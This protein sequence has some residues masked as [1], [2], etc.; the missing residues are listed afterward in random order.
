MI[1]KVC[2]RQQRGK[3]FICRTNFMTRELFAG[4]MGR[5][6]TP[7]NRNPDK[8]ELRFRMLAGIKK[9]R[10]TGPFKAYKLV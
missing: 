7:K 5:N 3:T 2:R 10:Y 4:G 6:R 8:S 9:A 1:L